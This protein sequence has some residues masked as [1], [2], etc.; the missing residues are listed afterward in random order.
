MVSGSFFYPFALAQIPLGL[1]LDRLGARSAMAILTL[2]GSV[3]AWVFA[4]SHG[5]AGAIAGRVLLGVG[6]AGNLMGFMK[7][8]TH[9][10]SPH[11]FA[12]RSGLLVAFGT[13]GNIAATAPLALLAEAVG[14]RWSFGLIGILTASLA[15]LFYVTVKERPGELN[16]PSSAGTPGDSTSKPSSGANILALLTNRNYWLISFGTFFRYGTLVAIQGLWAGPYLMECLGM[17]PIAAG[18]VLAFLNGGLILGSPMGGWI[19]DSV[20][21][22][23]KYVELRG[24]AGMALAE[25]ALSQ[26]WAQSHVWMLTG[27]FLLLA[28]SGAFGNVMYAHIKGLMPP[29]MT[30]LALMGINFFTMLGAG[31]Y[32]HAMGWVLSHWG[33]GSQ[34]GPEGYQAAFFLA[35]AGVAT[36]TVLYSFTQEAKW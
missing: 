3:G 29:E 7:L 4:V 27:V 18:T 24:L 33:S 5:P 28:F 25:M 30:G 9:W 14:W 26:G 10:F 34:T 36:A 6:M 13:L 31:I 11:E 12:T 16:T 1:M 22:S 8:L 19:S 15:V 17:S 35:F 20:L 21:H 23:R 32:I 2:V